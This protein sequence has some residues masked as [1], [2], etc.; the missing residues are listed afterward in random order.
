MDTLWQAIANTPWWVYV[1]L[2]YLI[3]LGIKATRRTKV[4]L[5]K[6]TIMPVI[7]TALSVHT[8]ITAF[9]IDFYSITLWVISILVGC[10]LGWIQVSRF[11]LRVDK[12][13]WIIEAPGTWSTL[14]LILI[15]FA[16]KYYFSYALAVDPGLTHNDWFELAMLGLS[17]LF[18]GLFIGRFI[19]YLYRLMSLPSVDLSSSAEE[20][21]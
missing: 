2:I 18:T 7:F 11:D 20:K 14:W 1:I 8:L 16:I 4:P 3:T 19:G 13:H 15:I 5:L 21:S 10:V 12:Q 6:L 17:G 9:K